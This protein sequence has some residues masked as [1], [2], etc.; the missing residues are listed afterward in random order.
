M[1]ILDKVN[2]K[3]KMLNND[4]EPM[5]VVNEDLTIYMLSWNEIKYK[6]GLCGFTFCK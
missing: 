1:S 4:E 2:I 6:M 3:I 5:L